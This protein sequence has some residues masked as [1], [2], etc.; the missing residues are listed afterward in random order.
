[1]VL[2][3]EPLA[4]AKVGLPV[5]FVQAADEFQAAL[6]DHHQVRPVAQQRI[7][8]ED[9]PRTKAVPQPAK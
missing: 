9:V 3:T 2:V 4:T 7:G 1:V 6:L 5:S 8:Q